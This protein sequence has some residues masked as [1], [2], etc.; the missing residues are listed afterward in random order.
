MSQDPTA[1]NGGDPY[2]KFKA[3]TAPHSQL[4]MAL[5]P[6]SIQG[7]TGQAAGL[8]SMGPLFGA[9]L[10]AAGG[11]LGG[12]LNS[13]PGM[14]GEPVA[15]KTSGEYL[16]DVMQMRTDFVA[17]LVHYVTVAEALGQTETTDWTSG[18]FPQLKQAVNTSQ[19]PEV[20]LAA[21]GRLRPQVGQGDPAHRAVNYFL[22][23][24]TGLNLLMSTLG[25][26]GG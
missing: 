9:A 24:L 6:Y 17:A 15:P 13:L 5:L 18:I 8:G 7:M 2:E 12:L 10:G 11:M 22:T 21:I 23:S 25:A 14:S 16:V 26:Q 19:E 1:T 3:L 4:T 20:L